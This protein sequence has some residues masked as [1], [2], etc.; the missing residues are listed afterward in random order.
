MYW[1]GY[2]FRHIR[3]RRNQVENLYRSATVSPTC[4][5]DETKTYFLFGGHFL[6]SNFRNNF[7]LSELM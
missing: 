2:A 3:R 6:L 7:L 4:P 5:P 1:L